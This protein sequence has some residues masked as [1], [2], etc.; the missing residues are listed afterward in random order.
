VITTSWDKNI[1]AIRSDSG[2]SVWKVN[3]GEFNY[4]FPLAVGDVLYYGTHTDLYWLE[5]ATGK[6]LRQKKVEYM[7]HVLP[8]KNHLF[9]DE[10]AITK[11]TMEGEFVK[12]LKRSAINP[13]RPV[14][15]NDYIVQADSTR[16][17]YGLTTELEILWR[18]RGEGLLCSPG[19]LH[20][21]V[22]FIG[23]RNGNVYAL[24][25]PT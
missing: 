1:H 21:G 13:F 24:Q 12:S 15:V 16:Y 22:Y 14:I 17:L 2:E 18:F 19:V 10:N 5:A 4:G 11:R 9:T 25:L 23:D 8:F 20:N 7:H 6:I 3:T